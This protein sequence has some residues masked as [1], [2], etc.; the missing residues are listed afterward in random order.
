MD[1]P[2]KPWHKPCHV[3]NKHMHMKMGKSVWKSTKSEFMQKYEERGKADPQ[4]FIGCQLPFQLEGI[5]S[6]GFNFRM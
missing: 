4:L 5:I 1:E 2:A 3:K 6:L